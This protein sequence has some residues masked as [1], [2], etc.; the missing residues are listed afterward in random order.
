MDVF[1]Y[2]KWAG[3]ELPELV[4]CFEPM[5]EEEIT[6]LQVGDTVWLDLEPYH[7]N[8]KVYGYSRVRITDEEEREYSGK[9]LRYFH[10][11]SEGH[12]GLFLADRR[13]RAFKLVDANKLERL[14]EG[15]GEQITSP[16]SELEQL[17]FKIFSQGWKD[18]GLP[19][20]ET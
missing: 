8:G 11:K 20:D 14:L 5:S 4:R 17:S 15:Y 18:A 2:N 16:Y 1:H 3:L 6:N 12:S 7:L 19:D 10:Y 9:R 13:A